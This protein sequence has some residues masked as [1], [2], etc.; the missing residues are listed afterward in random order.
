M[1]NKFNEVARENL[2]MTKHYLRKIKNLDEKVLQNS[3]ESLE[4]LITLANN[5]ATLNNNFVEFGEKVL[6]SLD[7]QNNMIYST[8]SEE[9]KKFFTLNT[10]VITPKTIQASTNKDEYS[11]N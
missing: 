11:Q 4:V 3:D 10:R 9:Q 6:A 5:I 7:N 2:S 1:E 8:L